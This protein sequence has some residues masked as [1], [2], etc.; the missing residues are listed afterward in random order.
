MRSSNEPPRPHRAS[1]GH[2]SYV[3][4]WCA[5]AAA[6]AD[7][8]CGLLGSRAAD[9]PDAKNITSVT[10]DELRLLGWTEGRNIQVESRWTGGDIEVRHKHAAELVAMAPEVILAIG[11]GAMGDLRRVTH[12]VPIV[13]V[14]V[15]DPVGAGYVRSLGKPGGNAHWFHAT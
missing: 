3:A 9:D 12:T 14:Q 4:A 13:F 1:R 15:S 6:R 7:A 8:A 2:S 10:L 11:S 5:C